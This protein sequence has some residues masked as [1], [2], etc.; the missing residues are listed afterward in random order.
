M[1]NSLLAKIAGWGQLAVQALTQ[2]ATL[3]VPT[4]VGG[5]AG[6]VASLAVAIGTHAASNT[7]GTK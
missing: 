4:G 1:N 2:F 3:G 5:W 6:L 7:E